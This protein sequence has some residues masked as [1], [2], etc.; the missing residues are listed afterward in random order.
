MEG[1]GPSLSASLKFFS[2]C[3]ALANVVPVLDTLFAELPAELDEL[4]T[5]I[6]GE[7]DEALEWT[8][9]LDAHSIQVRNS[10]EQLHLS[11]TNSVA[12]LLLALVAV[13]TGAR[14]FGLVLG[15]PRLVL[16]LR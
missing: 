3:E 5:P 4:A 10:L 8:L 14:S 12:R 15:D 1:S 9:E 2:A 13:W 7:I 11:A 6:R 16:E